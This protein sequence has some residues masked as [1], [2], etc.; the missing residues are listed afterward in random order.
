MTK[1]KL[2]PID[3][4]QQ[5]MFHIIE[6]SH[7][8]LLK[9]KEI[10]EEIIISRANDAYRQYRLSLEEGK[11]V[12]YANDTAREV[13]LD[14]L[15]WSPTDFIASLFYTEFGK[16]LNVEERVAEYFKHKEIFDKYSGI[17]LF[18]NDEKETELKDRFLASI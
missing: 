17:D 2:S 7:P 11:D 15:K 12:F 1:E 10:V 3:Y 6:I 4:W 5:Q 14:G 18:D 9:D 16:E 13:L 8:Y